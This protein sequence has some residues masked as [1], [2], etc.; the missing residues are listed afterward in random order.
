[1][2][3]GHNRDGTSGGRHRHSPRQHRPVSVF[4][5]TGREALLGQN[6]ANYNCHFLE[7]AM[8]FFAILLHSLLERRF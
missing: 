7:L 4:S 5:Y 8:I 6:A 3:S 1:M 2:N